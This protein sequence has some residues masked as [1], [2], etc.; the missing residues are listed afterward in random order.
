MCSITPCPDNNPIRCDNCQGYVDGECRCGL[1]RH[2]GKAREAGQYCEFIAYKEDNHVSTDV[3]AGVYRR[4]PKTA[5][6]EVA[7]DV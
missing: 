7:G 2:R 4:V 5:D 6:K 1:S 3:N